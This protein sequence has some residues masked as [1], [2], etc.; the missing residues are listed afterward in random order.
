MTVNTS[1]GT[2][3]LTLNDGG[4]ATYNGGSG[5]N[6]LTFSYTVGAGQN[7]PDLMV[8]A[9]NLDGATVQD[10]AGNAANLSLAGLSQGSPQIDTTAPTVT[11]VVA[12]AGELR[13]RQDGDADT[14]H[15][16]GRDGHRHTDAYAQRRRHRDL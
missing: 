6:A 1:G 5:T 13:Y 7:T 3:T 12:T 11:S 2:P 8:T 4:T 16:R 9:I 15:E 10:G 14:R